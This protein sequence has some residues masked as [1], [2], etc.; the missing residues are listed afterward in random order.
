MRFVC[1]DDSFIN[2][3]AG[4]RQRVDLWQEVILGLRPTDVKLTAPGSGQVQGE[5]YRC[6]TNSTG[7][8]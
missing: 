1:E 2:R 8:W 3:H 6:M 5:I 7:N 4:Q